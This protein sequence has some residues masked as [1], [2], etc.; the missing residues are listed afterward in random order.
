MPRRTGEKKRPLS[1][2]ARERLAVSGGRAEGL[3][4]RLWER[5]GA[6]RDGI[7]LPRRPARGEGGGPASARG[8]APGLAGGFED[9][10][11]VHEDARDDRRAARRDQFTGSVIATGSSTEMPSAV[12]RQPSVVRGQTREAGSGPPGP[13][14][15]PAVVARHHL[16]RMRTSSE[17]TAVVPAV[18]PSGASCGDG[19]AKPGA[20]RAVRPANAAVSATQRP[21]RRAKGR[22]AAADEEPEQAASDPA[23]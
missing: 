10:G 15:V 6:G 11:P 22:S 4:I 17:S 19:G 5:G 2:R 1:Y 12:S 9:T 21:W 18:G 7:G 13:A 23:S 16:T 20:V 8:R 14:G 3:R